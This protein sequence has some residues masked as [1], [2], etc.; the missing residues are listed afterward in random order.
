[1]VDV[2]IRL[3]ESDATT[4]DTNGIG[5]LP[6]AASCKV[7]EE[8]NGAFELAMTYPIKGLRYSELKL[9]RIIVAKP[10]PYSDPQPFRIYSISKPI[11]GIVTVNAEH[12]SY[13]MSGFPVTPFEAP[14]TAAALSGLKTHSAVPCPFNFWTDKTTTGTFKI[15]IPTNMRNCLGGMEGSILDVFGTGEYEFDKYDVK[16]Y[17]HRG[18]DRG[19]TL[20]YGKNITDLEQEENNANVYTGV[21]PYWYSEEDGYV[22]ASPQIING[23]GTYNYQRVYIL[24]LSYDWVDKP[25]SADLKAAAERYITNNNIGIPKVSLDVSFVHLSDSDEYADFKDLETVHLCDTVTVVFD[26]LGVNATAKCIKTVYDCLTDKYDSIS[27]GDSRTSLADTIADNKIS[28]NDK[29]N[30]QKSFLEQFVDN[31]TALITGNKGGY[32]VLHSSTGA[33]DPDE[34]L[35]MDTKDVKTAT[36]VWRWNRSGLGYSSK[37]Y[38]GPYSTAITADGKIVADFVSTGTMYANR[39]RGGILSMGGLN[40]AGGVIQILN[41]SNEVDGEWKNDGLRMHA[42]PLRIYGKTRDP[43]TN[44][45][46]DAEG[47]FGGNYINLDVNGKE[48]F[49]EGL[50]FSQ[51]HDGFMWGLM[52]SKDGKGLVFGKENDKGQLTTNFYIN[53]GGNTLGYDDSVVFFAEPRFAGGAKIGNTSMTV[54]LWVGNL[55]STPALFIENGGLYAYGS[56]GCSGEKYRIVETE[57]Y[58][59]RLLN[60]FETPEP[61]FGDFGSCTIGRNGTVKCEIEEIFAETIEVEDQYQVFLTKTNQAEFFA[62]M[63]EPWVEKFNSYF[64]VHGTPGAKYNYMVSAIQKGY[65]GVRL[66][67]SENM[68]AKAEKEE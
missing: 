5:Y 38:N 59:T 46:V 33:K 13:D 61:R 68:I 7:T 9:R 21:Y 43:I 35:I 14:Q 27:L 50:T 37:G 41:A 31:A 48:I 67:G 16:L 52:C 24:D 2:I 26:E 29:I 49:K 23:P 18:G 47:T 62:Y 10:N 56:I 44:A 45:L 51:N 28:T 58:G 39:I 55:N 6:D 60:A 32:V 66:K 42:S 53:N 19:V 20:R 40:N 17:L 22:T 12:I 3:F 11:R 25:T 15:N 4:F 8:R 63:T 64:I 65:S 57:H 30:E 34:L 1:M 54:E 36:K